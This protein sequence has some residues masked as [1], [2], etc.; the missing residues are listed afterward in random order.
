ML[1]HHDRKNLRQKSDYNKLKKFRGRVFKK[2]I[3]HTTTAGTKAKRQ[4]DSETPKKEVKSE[5][6]ITKVQ[7]EYLGKRFE[8]EQKDGNLMLMKDGTAD[9]IIDKMWETVKYIEKVASKTVF[10]KDH[11]EIWEEVVT[12]DIMEFEQVLDSVILDNQACRLM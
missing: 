3:P 10:V 11:K 6:V 8:L 7:V 1:K 5:D 2:V 9:Y 12:G 4:K